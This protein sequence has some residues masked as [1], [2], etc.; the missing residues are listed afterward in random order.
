MNGDKECPSGF[1]FAAYMTPDGTITS[2]T[3]HGNSASLGSHECVSV[4]D[5]SFR[6]GT[7]SSA[8]F[9][10]QVTDRARCMWPPLQ[11]PR[12]MKDTE[13]TFTVVID[14]LRNR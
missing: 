8:G 14:R 6:N 11:D 5:V 2:A 9:K 7:A 3:V 13:R 1:S 12:P 10:L 4:S